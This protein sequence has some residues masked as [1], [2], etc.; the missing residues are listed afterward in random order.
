MDLRTALIGLAAAML[1]LSSE[2]SPAKASDSCRLDNFAV[3]PV[4]MIDR[5]AVVTTTINGQEAPMTVDS[6]AV[7]SMITTP[8]AEALHLRLRPTLGDILLE[9]IT[10]LSDTQA[11]TV[12]Y[13]GLAG[14]MLHST[15]FIVSGGHIRS[16]TLG[17]IGQN[18]LHTGD[19]EYDLAD[20]MI[21]LMAPK[22]CGSQALA[23]WLKPDEGYAVIPINM[24]T[25]TEPSTIGVVLVNG[26]RTTAV[27]DTGSPNSM[28][29]R[30][31]AARIGLKLGSSALVD[32]G[33]TGGGGGGLVRTWT[34]PIASFKIGDEEIKNTQML[35]GDFNMS[36]ADM[37]VGIDFFLAHRIYVATSQRR[38]YL[39][40]AG[41]PVF[42]LSTKPPSSAT[43]PSS[44]DLHDAAD[45]AR[46]GAAYVDRNQLELALAD[47]TRATQMAPK[48]PAYFMNLARAQQA[49]EKP[50]KALA[51]V[52]EALKLKPNDVQA[53]VMHARLEETAGKWAAAIA[54]L[55]AA[56]KLAAKTDD[57]RLTLAGLYGR[58]DKLDAS[59]AQYDLWIR[60][61][62]EDSDLAS[63]Y[64]GRCWMRALQGEALDQALADCN[65]ALRM[66]PHDA[67][68]LDSRGL[69]FLRR[70]ELDRA[71][72]DYDAAL[73]LN[74]K[75]AW[76]LYG[77]GL[78]E[79]REG[80]GPQGEADLAAAKALEPE[81]PERARGYGV[82]R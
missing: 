56:D 14:F 11:T 74:P 77:R 78:V 36:D 4:T 23:Y 71:V 72:A 40:Y 10:G 17:L 51:S 35:V 32:A 81:L 62:D 20:G 37:L 42:D 48:E 31:A 7:F 52:D 59:V 66:A 50:D 58:A 34:A 6:G 2:P 30:R 53:L 75:L 1:A 76:S 69:V 70:G 73:K 8:N 67:D 24:T 25:A 43:R 47:L 65:A 26:V 22:G 16:G 13:F 5:R 41:G 12:K 44:T 79:Q 46:R 21:R 38:M 19:V 49:A 60:S 80:M 68:M 64:S 28:L 18:V 61:H 55:D 82:M 15:D 54:D 33:W 29:S 39:S 9:G 45:Y 57:V 27:F 3:L 63:A